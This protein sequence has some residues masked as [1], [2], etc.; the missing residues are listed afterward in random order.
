MKVGERGQVTIPKDMRDR[1]GIGPHSEVEFTVEK[2]ALVL[3]KAP[4]RLN[5][6]KWRGHCRDRFES[7]GF[8]S[9]DEFI[10]EVRG[11]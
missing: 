8:S 1:L 6:D 11:S 9:V 7:L 10:E 3:R 2:G 4:K 5:L